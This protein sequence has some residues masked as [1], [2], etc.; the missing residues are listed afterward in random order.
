MYN[1]TFFSYKA[2]TKVIRK[3]TNTRRVSKIYYT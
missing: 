2:K 3:M 1:Y